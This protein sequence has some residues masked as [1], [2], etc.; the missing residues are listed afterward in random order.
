MAVATPLVT[1]V[2]PTVA[3]VA[4]A[5]IDRM[6]MVL[7][8]M[9][10]HPAARP[11]GH[12]SRVTGVPACCSATV[13]ISIAVGG[14]LLVDAV[15]ETMPP[16][17]MTPMAGDAATPVGAAGTVPAVVTVSAPGL[18]S[19]DVTPVGD[20]D[21]ITEVDTLAPVTM[22]TTVS[23]GR[24]VPLVKGAPLLV[25]VTALPTGAWQTQPVP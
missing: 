15:T 18:A 11:D 2:M 20:E 14:R 12:G 17:A 16:P 1:T 19:T 25:Q 23:P 9:L 4:L 7:P 3:A 6:T 13:P 8:S 10:K 22:A 24:A 5:G 21:W